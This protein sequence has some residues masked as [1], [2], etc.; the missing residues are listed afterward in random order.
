MTENKTKVTITMNEN[1]AY[2]VK[3]LLEF[4]TR[5][6][7]GQFE[8]LDALFTHQTKNTFWRDDRRRAD[9]KVHMQAARQDI[10]PELHP[11]S[12]LG[13]G[14]AETPEIAKV[15]WDVFKTIDH[16]LAYNKHPG[17]KYPG[18]PKTVN[19]DAVRGKSQEPLPAVTVITEPE[20][21]DEDL[22]R[23]IGRLEYAYLNNQDVGYVVAGGG[24]MTISHEAIPIIRSWFSDEALSVVSK[25]KTDVKKKPKVKK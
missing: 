22:E 20:K 14:G 1:Q 13:I 16:A 10:Y 8:E 15:A 19:F 6:L 11:G 3:N 23:F 9:L 7:I 2:V 4:S 5:M 21:R 25:K 18:F 24:L 12:Y 17:G